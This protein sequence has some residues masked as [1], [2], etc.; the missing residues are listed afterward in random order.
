LMT[1]DLPQE[2]E[3]E[4]ESVDP[5]RTYWNRLFSRMYETSLVAL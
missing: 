3:A 1:P 2:L 5:T 4:Y